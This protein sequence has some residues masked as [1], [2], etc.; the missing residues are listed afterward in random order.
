MGADLKVRPTYVRRRSLPGFFLPPPAGRARPLSDDQSP[1]AN[2][3]RRWRPPAT[4]CAADRPGLR[5]RGAPQAPGIV[6]PRNG[7][8]ARRLRRKRSRMRCRNCNPPHNCILGRKR[9]SHRAKRMRKF[10][11]SCRTWSRIRSSLEP[12]WLFGS[13]ARYL[14]RRGT[15]PL[16]EG[17]NPSD[18]NEK[19]IRR[20]PVG[21]VPF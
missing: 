5:P 2:C 10:G 7:S 3:R 15:T 21:R 8:W 19:A 20:F 16:N 13:N 18:L 9:S 4:S 12:P 17:A 1:D 11:C 6:T 14:A